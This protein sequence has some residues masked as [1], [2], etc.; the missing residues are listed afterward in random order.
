MRPA[1]LKVEVP[2]PAFRVQSV[3]NRK[4]FE[5][6]RFPAAVFADEKRDLGVKGEPFKISDHGQTIRVLVERRH[7]IAEQLGME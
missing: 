7:E 3:S 5:E 4:G 2:R 6:R 1:R